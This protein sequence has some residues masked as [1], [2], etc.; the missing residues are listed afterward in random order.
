[1]TQDEAVH[2]VATW[3]AGMLQGGT[4]AEATGLEPDSL[5]DADVERLG[6]AVETVVDR[7]YRMGKGGR[8]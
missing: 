4:F 2:E 3:A 8:S 5:S 7:L 6:K 1:M